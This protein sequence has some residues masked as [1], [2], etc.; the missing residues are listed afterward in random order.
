[1]WLHFEVK[2][3]IFHPRIWGLFYLFRYC[4]GVEEA[5]TMEDCRRKVNEKSFA[6]AAISV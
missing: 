6:I 5:E 4:S 1:M 2:E 3:T